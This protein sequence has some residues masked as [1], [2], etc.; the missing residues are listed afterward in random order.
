M[1][2]RDAVESRYSCRAFLSTPISIETV[3]DILNR[4]AR[5]PS[6]GNV[7]PWL[8][9]VLA[10]ERLEDL[11]NQ[12]VSDGVVAR[13]AGRMEFGA[14]ALGN[15]SIL[16]NPSDHRVVPLINR[17]IK[18]RDFWMPF[19]P[20][21][22][23]EREADYLVNP[24]GFDSPHMMLAFAT[25]PKRRD[26][27]VAAVHPH[28][29]TARAHILEEACESRL[30]PRGARVRAPDGYRRRAQHVLQPARRAAGLLGRGR[31]RHLRA[32]RTPA[33]GPRPLP[34]LQAVGGRSPAARPMRVLVTGGAGY[35]GSHT[36]KALAAAGHLP[37]VLDTLERRAPRAVRWGPLVRGRPRR[38]GRPRGG[39]TRASASR[40]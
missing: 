22:L 19:A 27:I 33:S 39:A 18:N 15:R 35:I 23:R 3:K 4:A 32:L 26:D 2:V 31:R 25:N 10:G 16:G 28:D 5:A 38:P 8:V 12:M 7:Q 29:G 21:I 6:G 40:P 14:R 34:D 36:A 24:R 37:V 9:H 13:C 11:K 1:D 20:T 17:M 30:P